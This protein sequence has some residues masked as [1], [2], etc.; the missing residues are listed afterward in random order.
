LS[1]LLGAFD[2]FLHKDTET[3]LISPLRP[4]P[5]LRLGPTLAKKGL[6]DQTPQRRSDTGER[7]TSR[8]RYFQHW[9]QEQKRESNATTKDEQVA[10]GPDARSDCPSAGETL[11]GVGQRIRSNKRGYE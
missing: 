6:R 10:G 1:A 11:D 7:G 5:E 4:W 8:Y 2:S 3:F 9:E